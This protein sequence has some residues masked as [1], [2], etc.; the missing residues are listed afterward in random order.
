M[1][2][3]P[4]S[5][6]G[7]ADAAASKKTQD[8]IDE[9]K[10]AIDAASSDYLRGVGAHSP[11]RI[12][13]MVYAVAFAVAMVLS[14]PPLLVIRLLTSPPPLPLPTVYILTTATSPPPYPHHEQNDARAVTPQTT[15][16]CLADLIP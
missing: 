6:C 7:R 14:P 5:R 13:D 10:T 4:S 9:L 11:R 3:R 16:A 15:T 12:L 1:S 8:V 2:E